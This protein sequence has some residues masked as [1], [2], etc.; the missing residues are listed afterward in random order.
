MDPVR[1]AAAAIEAQPIDRND[2][3]LLRALAL[4]IDYDRGRDLRRA[5]RS[6]G[7]R[8]PRRAS[9]VGTVA[10]VAA[11]LDAD[12][13]DHGRTA[14]SDIAIRALVESLL[15]RSPRVAQG[16]LV[17]V[18]ERCI[19]AELGH[20]PVEHFASVAAHAEFRAELAL[21]I[22]RRVAGVEVSSPERMLTEL[23]DALR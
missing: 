6:V 1:A 16:F 12:C 8:A 14:L 17:R 19:L 5:C 15:D 11:M 22:K 4:V 9:P 10:A 3:T 18:A 21:H 23:G 13:D 20:A 2:A 7:L